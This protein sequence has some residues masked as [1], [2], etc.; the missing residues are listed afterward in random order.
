MPL[1]RRVKVLH[2]TY[3]TG[4]TPIWERRKSSMDMKNDYT[5]LFREDKVVLLPLVNRSKIYEMMCELDGVFLHSVIVRPRFEEW[6]D[7]IAGRAVM[8]AAYLGDMAVGCCAFYMN[9]FM[10][11]TAYITYIAVKEEYQNIHIGTALVRYVKQAAAV[12]GIRRIRLEVDKENVNAI[13]F[14]EKNAFIW[15]S[16]ASESSDYMACML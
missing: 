2:R 11:G 5:S 15:E 1:C 14:Y 12:N 4:E 13:R 3:R 6:V 8:I 16:R 7:K 9:D 10:S